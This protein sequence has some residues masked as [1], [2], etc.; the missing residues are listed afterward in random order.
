MKK[1][2]RSEELFIIN[3]N[4]DKLNQD[5]LNF[6]DVEKLNQGRIFTIT[7]SRSIYRT[8]RPASG[9]FSGNRKE[10]KYRNRSCYRASLYLQ[11]DPFA[12]DR[13]SITSSITRSSTRMKTASSKYVL[14]KGECLFLIGCRQWNRIPED[15][16]ES[17]FEPYNQVSSDKRNIRESGWAIH[18]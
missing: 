5:I 17:I 16:L 4:L 12:I 3:Q 11:A 10:E 9:A 18:R 7:T 1:A 14:K 13:F 6:L 8:S 15:K 2:D